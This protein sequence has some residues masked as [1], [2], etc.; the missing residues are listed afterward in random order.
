LGH[1]DRDTLAARKALA[2]TCLRQG[3]YAEAENLIDVA[4]Y[5]KV[6][7]KEHPSTLTGVENFADV[8]RALG[9]LGKAEQLVS[10]SYVRRI[11]IQGVKAEAT[12]RA[13]LSACEYA[14][15]TRQSQRGSEVARAA[16]FTE[17]GPP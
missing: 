5:E 13:G 1:H 16:N 3:K 7:G 8:Q 17:L 6:L 15:R 10:S 14:S 2:L 4:Y 11:G 12:V 9:R